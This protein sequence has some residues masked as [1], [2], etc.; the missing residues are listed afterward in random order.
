V[1]DLTGKQLGQYQIVAPL[2]E[3]GMAAVYKAY[4]LGKMNRYVALKIL[5][6]QLAKSPQFVKRFDQEANVLA[7]LQHPRILPVFD[8]GESEGYAYLAM[9]FIESGTL[10]DLLHGEPLP[11]PQIRSL[12][13]Q[14]A[15]AL[16]YAHSRGLVHRDV[17]P[18]NVLVDERGNCLLSDFGIAKILEGT[19]QFTATGGIIGTP[20]YMSPEQGRGETLDGRSDIYSLGVMLFEMATGRVP[21]NAETP[22]AVII[23]HMQDPLPPP[24]SINPSLPEAVEHVIFKA[25]AK[26]G[27]DRYRTADE[28]ARALLAAIP[29][30]AALS[31]QAEIASTLL[32]T[33]A[34]TTQ[35]KAKTQT[36]PPVL[37]TEMP[38]THFP[39]WV[40][41]LGGLA[42]TATIAFA[43]LTGASAIFNAATRRT[44]TQ[45]GL[46]VTTAE[47]ATV[48]PSPLAPTAA[49]T[50]T[51]VPP[52][53]TATQRP[54]QAPSMYEFS[55]CLQPCNGTNS[56]RALPEGATRIYAQWSYE[57][58][59]IGV[60]YTRTWTMN[61]REWIRYTCTWP[62]PTT[63]TDTVTL[64]EPK[65]LH[66]GT[67][68][69]T[70][71]IDGV[72]LLKG[73]V[74]VE[75]DWDYWDPAGSFNRCY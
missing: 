3:G 45:L 66:S 62:G 57:N 54:V 55:T 26:H 74:L 8:F 16:D 7:K 58:I 12:I 50:F 47:P 30:P 40:L 24:R 21:Y 71:T 49:S 18:S 67:W 73:Q 39:R 20:A 6:Q 59:P 36:K 53:E 48:P 13:V 56:T 19:E 10:A 33:R 44:P 27:E 72:V 63:G 31:D 64:T 28:M 43:V 42:L 11:L 1:E 25:L 2:G 5:P 17:K 9:P 41:A 61:D 38:K 29:E 22:L 4:Q 68:E 34:A 69:V 70:I 52:T 75:G 15:E 65:G 60:S 46:V 32:E 35:A 51:P 14:V 23:K 37:R